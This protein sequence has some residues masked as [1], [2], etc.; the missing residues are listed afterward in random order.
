[1]ALERSTPKRLGLFFTEDWLAVL[2]GLL[3]VS[4]VL[5]GLLKNIP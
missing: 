4:L 5:A 1:M 3:L 2:V